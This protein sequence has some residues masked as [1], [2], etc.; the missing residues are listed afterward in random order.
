MSRGIVKTL[1]V[2]AILVSTGWGAV[3]EAA[4]QKTYPLFFIERSKNRNRVHYDACLTERNEL[5]ESG[6]V[7]AYWVLENGQRGELNII[8]RKYAY[9]VSS[10]AKTGKESAWFTLAALKNR[11]VSIRKIGGA[12]KAIM[13][14]RGQEVILD[15]V[16]IAS[17]ERR[18]RQPKVLYVDLFG[19]A[20]KGNAPV[21]ERIVPR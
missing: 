21:K 9:G 2:I 7:I 11:K 8:E 5:S 18:L 17:R 19:H 14:V 15:R 6:P 3:A 10:S 12:Y 13:A 16:F 4:C 20:V 1:A